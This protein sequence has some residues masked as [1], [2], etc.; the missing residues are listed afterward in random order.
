MIMAT[1][2]TGI[3]LNT[4]FIIDPISH[5]CKGPLASE[6]NDPNYSGNQAARVVTANTIIMETEYYAT[7]SF[8]GNFLISTIYGTD[9]G[10]D[11][12][13][14]LEFW[15]KLPEDEEGTHNPDTDMY[16]TG[17]SPGYNIAEGLRFFNQRYQYKFIIRT[18]PWWNGTYA[19]IDLI[20]FIRTN[21]NNSMN[22]TG[23]SYEPEL[24]GA[25]EWTDRGT[26]DIPHTTGQFGSV[27]VN[28]NVT[29][30]EPPTITFGAVKNNSG[31]N[32]RFIPSQDAWTTTG[33]TLEVVTHDDQSWGGV[34]SVDWVAEGRIA[35]IAV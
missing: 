7:D 4:S 23:Y 11:T 9:Y 28:F 30:L 17:G 26:A 25:Q 16:F 35:I 33:F 5:G 21:K 19:D 31:A 3:P 8:T 14:V 6:I 27:H 22:Y 34:A 13:F 32:S 15:R 24:A 20:Q 18:T 10:D 1:E 2:I 12:G 29:F